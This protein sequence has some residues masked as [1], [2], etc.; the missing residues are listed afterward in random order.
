MS[1]PFRLQPLLNLAQIKNESATKRL[2]ELNKLQHDSE[3]QLETLRQYRRDYQ[4]RMQ[5]ASQQGVDPIVLRNF[6]QFI[7]KLDAAIVQQLKAVEQNRLSTQAGLNDYG[8]TQR[9]LKSFDTLQQRHIES[10]LK[11]EA[12]QEQKAMDEHSGRVTA[13]KMLNTEK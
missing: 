10:E 3:V 1:N 13:Y 11:I 9:K 2:G 7:Y 4:E 5:T 6:Q 8:G 12:K